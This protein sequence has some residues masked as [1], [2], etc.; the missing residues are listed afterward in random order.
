MQPGKY[1]PNNIDFQYKLD[2]N[3]I[4]NSVFD[5]TKKI[6]KFSLLRM[7]KQKRESI[8]A[9]IKLD[10]GEGHI[11]ESESAKI[12]LENAIRDIYSLFS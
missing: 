5:I 7:E 8:L 6:G 1:P 11:S 4:T 12:E 9:S 2:S 3:Y 10:D